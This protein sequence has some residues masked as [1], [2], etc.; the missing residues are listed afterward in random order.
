LRPALLNP[1]PTR[2]IE[3]RR[4]LNPQ[5]TAA[6]GSRSNGSGS[7]QLESASQT[8]AALAVLR[9]TPQVSLYSQKYPS[10]LEVFL[11]FSPFSLF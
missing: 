4:I 11:Q 9:K 6:I 8:P 7:T 3:S 5:A 10:T 1:D 2:R